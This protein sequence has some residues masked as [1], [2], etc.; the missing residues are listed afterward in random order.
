MSKQLNFFIVPDDLVSIYD[1]FNAHG[2]RYTPARSK[3]PDDL[4]LY[5]FPFKHGKDYEQN[6]LTSKE[7]T[8][9]LT[10]IYDEKKQIYS[11]D[12]QK[13]YVLEFDP[14]GFYP[15]SSKVLHRA[16]FYCKTSYFVTNNES[17]VKSD[18]FKCWVDKI[19]RLFK[20][21]FLIRTDYDKS[22]LFSERAV[23]WMKENNGKIDVPFLK[24]TI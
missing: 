10:F 24:I 6:Y 7:F 20:K 18:E 12:L 1:F 5:T 17:V 2:V 14:G 19:F 22:I 9:Y 4:V 23:S 15:S 16:R 13:S 11:L 8:D 21:Q 3:S